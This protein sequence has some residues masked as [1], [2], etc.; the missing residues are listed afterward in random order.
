MAIGVLEQGGGGIRAGAGVGEWHAAL[1][2]LHAR[3]QRDRR[4]Q[5]DEV[6]AT[7]GMPRHDAP[8]AHGPAA[9]VGRTSLPTPSD[10]SDSGREAPSSAPWLGGAMGGAQPLHRA[11]VAPLSAP[12]RVVQQA[13]CSGLANG[14]EEVSASSAV[15]SLELW[16]ERMSSEVPSPLIETRPKTAV[17]L[18]CIRSPTD[19]GARASHRLNLSTHPPRSTISAS[20]ARTVR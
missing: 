8:S 19:T 6:I 14:V 15:E 7:L 20:G 17:T 4:K 16:I 13:S 12:Q 2:E 5:A 10:G 9:S 11:G 3:R 1:R 18:P